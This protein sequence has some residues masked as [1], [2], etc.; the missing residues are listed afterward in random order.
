MQPGVSGVGAMA[1]H[2]ATSATPRALPRSGA[3]V[4]TI[5]VFPK[6]RRLSNRRAGCRQRCRP[7][8]RPGIHPQRKLIAGTGPAVVFFRPREHFQPLGWRN[9]NCRTRLRFWL[10][11]FLALG[12]LASGASAGYCFCGQACTPGPQ[13]EKNANRP[14]HPCCP[15]ASCRSCAWED[16]ST[17]RSS[18]PSRPSP[19]GLPLDM[20]GPAPGMP[21]SSLPSHSWEEFP[22]PDLFRPLPA[23]HLY[24]LNRSLLI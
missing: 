12:I 23:P 1:V 11:F 14:F 4:W 7:C 13:P 15:G 9:V 6:G 16:A 20:A 5:A 17:L 2:G 8:P 18:S 3:A 10:S 24:L 21:V 22:L 19:D